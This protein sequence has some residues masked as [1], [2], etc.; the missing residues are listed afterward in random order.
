[1]K[2]Q[3][4][5]LLNAIGCKQ[6]AMSQHPYFKQGLHILLPKVDFFIQLNL[7]AK[8]FATFYEKCL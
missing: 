1:V 6:D 3:A 5:M 2:S 7:C 8:S 4:N